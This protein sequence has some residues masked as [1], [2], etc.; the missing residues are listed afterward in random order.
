MR[1]VFRALYLTYAA[2]C[3]ALLMAAFLI[4]AA[5]TLAPAVL[6]PMPA[7]CVFGL[8]AVGQRRRVTTGN[9]GTARFASGR[10]LEGMH[11]HPEGVILGRADRTLRPNFAQTVGPLFQAPWRRSDAVVKRLLNPTRNAKRGELIRLPD[12]THLCAVSPAGRGKGVSYALPNLY[13]CAMSMIVN[14]PKGELFQKTAHH[15]ARRFK[16]RIV[17]LAP[18]GDRSDQFNVLKLIDPKHRLALDQCADMADAIVVRTG[19]ETDPHWNNCAVLFLKSIIAFVVAHG[20]PEEKNLQTVRDILTNPEALQRAITAMQGSDAMGGMLRRQGHALTHYKGEELGSVLTTVGRH[21]AFLDSLPVASSMR[22]STF[23]PSELRRGRMTIYLTIP[24]D[25]LHTQAG[26]LRLWIVSLLRIL[27][28]NGPDECNPVMFLLDEAG[29][30]GKFQALEDSITLLRGYGI[31][32]F[33]FYQS[34]SQVKECFGEAGKFWDNMD[35]RIYW[36]LNDY[37][38]AEAVSK[39]C[40]TETIVTRTKQ[41]GDSHSHPTGSSVGSPKQPGNY[42][43]NT[44]TTTAESARELIKPDEVLRMPSDRVIILHRNLPPIYAQRVISY[45]DPEFRRAGLRRLCRARGAI[46]FEAG[47]QALFLLAAS[48]SYAA[49]IAIGVFNWTP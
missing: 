8:L 30:I 45:L 47:L 48:A 6:Y 20:S 19:H 23:D 17:H 9:F 39:Q 12:P 38:S 21:T 28:R 43:T 18:F 31:R 22:A 24:E 7:I 37:T 35:T 10:D 40:G 11:G 15:R 32:L 25:Q 41:R 2:A 36:G 49:G 29:H 16:H 42:S 5:A 13:G 27:T 26:L 33:F 44:S 46:G 14:D 34:V 3:R 4:M 1:Y